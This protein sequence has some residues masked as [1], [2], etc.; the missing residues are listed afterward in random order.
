[1][2]YLDHTFPDAGGAGGF[3]QSG[4]AT[5]GDAAGNIVDGVDTS[6]YTTRRKRAQDSG[7]AGGNAY[8]GASSN[9]DGGNVIND[10]DNQGTTTNGA[11][12]ESLSMNQADWR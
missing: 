1:M 6:R 5:G 8:T 11:A 10:S 2:L 12:R 4:D 7:T 9:V 3:D